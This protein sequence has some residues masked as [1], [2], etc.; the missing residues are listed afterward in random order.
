M[1]P[2]LADFDNPPAFPFPA[3]NPVL[4]P[5]FSLSFPITECNAPVE[6]L[7][8]IPTESFTLATFINNGFFI[9]NGLI[10]GDELDGEGATAFGLVVTVA[11]VK[12]EELGGEEER[13]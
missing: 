13:G 5:F 2:K 11:T 1:L 12:E 10:M 3:A 6:L 8:N 7:P 4:D 9:L